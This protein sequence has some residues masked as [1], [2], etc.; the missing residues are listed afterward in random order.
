MERIN[1]PL[2]NG[3]KLSVVYK[4]Q[5]IPLL[6]NKVYPSIDEAQ[7]AITGNVT[8]MQCPDCNY[9]FNVDFDPG[10]I[11]YDEQYQ[12]EQ[13][14]SEYFQDY[15][16]SIIDL[17]KSQK[18]NESKIV[19][20]GC[21]KGFFLERMRENHFHITGFDPAYEGENP[22]IIKDY[23]SDQYS[24]LDAD[25]IV[26]RHVLEHVPDPLVFLHSIAKALNYTGKI[27]IEVPSLE[28]ILNKGAFWDIFYEHCNYFTFSSLKAMF[29]T[30]MQ[31]VLF[32]NQYMFLI[33][34][35]SDLQDQAGVCSSNQCR[36]SDFSYLFKK[37]ELYKDF[38]KKHAGMVIWGAGAKGA[39]FV[40]LV[41]PDRKHISGVIDINP[42]KQGGYI[43]K[44]GHEVISPIRLN[45]HE[46]NEIF[47]M[48][49]NYYDEV[50]ASLTGVNANLYV[51]GQINESS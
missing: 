23:F 37:L 7:K 36:Q 42:K 48:N 4:V 46:V 13:A 11:V 5:N 31:G 34:D 2:C 8:L 9:I 3:V 47:I 39:T 25:L 10:R 1:C 44:T 43:G 18:F 30:A 38:V 49:E 26:L 28:W 14:H 33:A 17:F 27:Y 51:L 24:N 19:E 41:D 45:K 32:N 16:K 22:N 40:N 12:N 15:L 50:K 35:L 6:Q 20:I 21:G 29:K